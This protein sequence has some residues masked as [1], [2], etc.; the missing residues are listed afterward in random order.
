VREPRLVSLRRFV[1]TVAA[2]FIAVVAVVTC[3]GA[4]IED[5]T[6]R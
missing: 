4:L 1:L 5:V 6:R 2:L 3:G